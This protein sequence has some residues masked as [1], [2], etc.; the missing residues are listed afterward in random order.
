MNSHNRSFTEL[1]NS[2]PFA[3]VVFFLPECTT[4]AEVQMTLFTV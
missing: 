1:Y 2:L 3:C 4:S